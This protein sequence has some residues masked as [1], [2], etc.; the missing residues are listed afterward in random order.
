MVDSLIM[1]LAW[2]IKV[3]QILAENLLK[4]DKDRRLNIRAEKLLLKNVD[5][6]SIEFGKLP[7]IVVMSKLMKTSLSITSTPK[8]AKTTLSW[9]M[10]CS[11]S[12]T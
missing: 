4:V 1:A 12:S 11:M 3:N 9:L 5:L 2:L 6:S 7:L 10:T 8:I